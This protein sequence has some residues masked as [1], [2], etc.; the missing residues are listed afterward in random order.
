MPESADD[1]VRS[2][3]ECALWDEDE[4]CELIGRAKRYI[5]FFPIFGDEKDE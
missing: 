1:I 2:L 4:L 3:A 5:Q